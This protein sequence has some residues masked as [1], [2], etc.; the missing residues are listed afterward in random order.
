MAKIKARESQNVEYKSSWHDEYL[1]W[2]CGFANAQ[3]AVMYFGVDNDHEVVGLENVDRLMEDIPNK[4]VTT[5]GI[6]V[7]VN[8]LEQ[9]GL[10]Y[11]EVVIEPSNIPIN[12]RGKYYYRSGSTMQELRG[13][14]L[15][16]F[17]LKKMGRSWDDVTNDRAT[18]DDLD[19]SAID[20]FLRKG[21]EN[22]RISDEERSLPV[23]TLLQN[24]DLIN[25]EGKLKNAALLLFAKRP[26]RYFTSVRFNIG[27]FSGSESNLI[28]QDVIE[29][30]IIQMAD[31]V[32]EILKSKYLT[33]PITFKGMNRIEKLEVPEEALREI[34]YNAIIHKDYTGVHI[35]MRVWDDYCEVWNEGD[36]PIGFTPETLLG[37]H[38]SRPRNRNIANAFFKAG[39]I[40]AWG[41]G[42]KKIREGFEGAG[43]PMPKIESAFG[44]VRVTFQRNNVNVSKT[45]AEI[46][47]ERQ[48]PSDK[49]LSQ[50]LSPVLSPVCPQLTDSLLSKIGAVIAA[51]IQE[52]GSISELMEHAGEKNKNR[53]RQNVLN[54]LVITGLIELTIP[55]IPNSP[56]QKYALTE[57]G[58]ALIQT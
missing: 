18:I 29:G 32:M 38:A 57:K 6:V 4:I 10:E 48:T 2:I 54:P 40:D 33:M 26:Q 16:Q 36:L 11:I 44:G 51:L 58:K 45:A 52:N 39:F 30:N 42:Y 15:Q 3:G 12:Y 5:M 13:P 49:D 55:D 31:R 28:T 1:K 43:L 46:I 27:R 22:G 41:R 7:D 25:E 23:E 47:Y 35:Q 9:D 24:L 17:V 8:L 21:Y 37:Q 50:A 20:Y 34:L 56:K 14:A 19:K 53:F